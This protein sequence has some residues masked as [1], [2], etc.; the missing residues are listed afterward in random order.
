MNTYEKSLEYAKKM[1]EED[2]IGSFRELFYYPTDT[3]KQIYFCGN[4][5]GLQPK[6]AKEEIEKMLETWKNK[7]VKGWFTG[8][9]D[10]LNFN[11]SLE[12][13]LARI[14]G[15][16]PEEVTLMNGLTVNLHLLFVSFYQPTKERFKILMEEHAFPSDQYAI[17]SQL[18]FHGINPEEGIIE[19]KARP[20]EKILKTENILEMIEEYGE[21][22]AI[23][24]FPGMQYLTG[25][26]FEMKAIAQKAHEKG[27]FVG[28]DLA[29]SVGNI[30]HKLHDWEVDFAVWCN[31]KYI[32]GGPG[33][34]GG[35]F[36]HEKHFN[37]D[38][39]RFEGWWGGKRETLMLMEPEI[40]PIIGAAG[41]QISSHPLLQYASLKASLDIF[42][43]LPLEEY[44]SKS[45]KLTGFLEFL[46]TNLGF[47][48]YQIITPTNPDKRGCQL[49]IGT[50]KNGKELYDKLTNNGI[51]VDWREPNVIR[52][53]PHPLYN[54]YE[55]VFT[56]SE[57]L[58]KA[59]QS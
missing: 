20:G 43:D 40:D 30:P 25:Q 47:D 46:I 36:V 49:S 34:V 39:N 2:P 1:D 55:E 13:S 7:A 57:I 45:K 54:T 16:K 27:C 3:Q 35:C 15:A 10:W 9:P 58:R 22:I 21:E 50:I 18:R 53:A 42:D 23:V 17:K 24:W 32:S 4:S 8:E 29:H 41:W 6:K 31:Y 11:L 48:N 51:V 5:L 28:F 52:V 14:V 19:C 12:K 33:A 26:A 38:L 59:V 37:K 56:F 44:Y